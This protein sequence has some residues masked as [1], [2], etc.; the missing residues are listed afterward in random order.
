MSFSKTVPEEPHS[1][2]KNGGFL[3]ILFGHLQPNYNLV[4][5]KR[6]IN[7]LGSRPPPAKK[8]PHSLF[9][10]LRTKTGENIAL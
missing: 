6:Y 1:S 9:D 5:V 4:S 8:N 3:A 7:W 10:G 2:G